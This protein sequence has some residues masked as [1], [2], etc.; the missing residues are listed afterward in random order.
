MLPMDLGEMCPGLVTLGGSWSWKFHP[1]RRF[2]MVGKRS[3][4]NCLGAN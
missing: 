4:V 1:N 2:L 3:R